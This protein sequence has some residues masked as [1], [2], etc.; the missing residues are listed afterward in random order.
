MKKAHQSKRTLRSKYGF[1]LVEVMVAMVIFLVASVSIAQL[2]AMTTRM[3]LQ[4]HNGTEATRLAE[5]KLDELKTLDFDIDPSIQ[6]TTGDAL[7]TD[8]A[9]YFDL[10]ATGVVRRWSVTPGPTASTRTI[11]V[12]VIDSAGSLGARTVDLTTVL[13]RW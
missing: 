12:R 9:N 8:I 5:A 13:R 1:S 11:T 2:L 3:H 4:A 10:P 7:N 6:I